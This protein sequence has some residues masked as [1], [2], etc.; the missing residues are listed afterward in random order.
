[1][2]QLLNEEIEFSIAQSYLQ[3]R[4]DNERVDVRCIRGWLG[5][6]EE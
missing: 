2:R 6:G 5:Q 4:G 1:V 3:L